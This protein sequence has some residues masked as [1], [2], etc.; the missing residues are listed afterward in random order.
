M[1][2]IVQARRNIN[3]LFPSHCGMKTSLFKQNETAILDISRLCANEDDF[4]NRVLS[5]S[6]LVGEI[7]G[8]ALKSQIRAQRGDLGRSIGILEAWLEES[9]PDYDRRII[10]NLRMIQTLRSKKYPIHVD[11]TE[12]VQAL[13][14]FRFTFPITDWQGLWEA[15]LRAYLESLEGLEEVLRLGCEQKLQEM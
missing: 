1:A 5:L 13:Q 6:S 8:N 4:N 10:K 7:E 14:Y 2:R 15:V 12:F 3:L 11:T 9:W